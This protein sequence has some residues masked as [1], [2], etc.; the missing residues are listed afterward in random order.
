[1]NATAVHTEILTY[2][3]PPPCV[4]TMQQCRGCFGWQNMIKAAYDNNVW[5]QYPL[6]CSCTGL[7]L[8]IVENE[9]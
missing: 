7:V 5:R 1:M 8:K 4:N 2:G 6:R 3:S 9:K